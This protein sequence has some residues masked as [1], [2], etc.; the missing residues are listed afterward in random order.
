MRIQLLGGNL[1]NCGLFSILCPIHTLQVPP[2]AVAIV[3]YE[4]PI[5]LIEA[6]CGAVSSAGNSNPPAADRLNNE[7][8]S[9][10]SDIAS[11]ECNQVAEQQQQQQ[12]VGVSVDDGSRGGATLPAMTAVQE[13]SAAAAAASSTA[14]SAH[15]GTVV[16]SEKVSR[17]SKRKK[18]KTSLSDIKEMSH[19]ISKWQK[20][21]EDL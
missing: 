5:A 18:V 20:A 14:T 13:V 9:F 2:G 1:L 8:D 4:M 15:K 10:Y 21:Q 17:G 6:E 11:I 16:V 19:L 7:L 12:S 3:D